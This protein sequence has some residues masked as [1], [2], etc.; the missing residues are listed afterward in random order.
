[1]KEVQPGASDPDVL[2]LSHSE[3][4]ILIT[5]D[6]GFGRLAI[7][8]KEPAYGI[9]IIA[10]PALGATPLAKIA[11]R[12]LSEMEDQLV[13]QLTIVEAGRVR[14]RHLPR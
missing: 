9:A 11:C 5:E 6:H 8:L 10:M 14:Q 2:E 13:G 12:V 4:R 1:M 3:S 7:A